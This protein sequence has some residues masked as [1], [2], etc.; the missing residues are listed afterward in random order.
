MI[1]IQKAQRSDLEDILALQ[2]LAYQSEAE[3]YDDP[4]IP[5]L[6]QTIEELGGEFDSG[7]ILKAVDE[8]GTIIG[9]V[10]AHAEDGNVY[11]G[12]LMVHP[13]M[14]R[15]GLGTKL[16]GAIEQEYPNSRYELFTGT[17]SIGNIRLYQRLGYRIF[18]QEQISEDLSF[19]YLEKK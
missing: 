7:T 17:K 9:S 16:L 12:R 19:V 6:K 14:Q 11:I 5:P 8:N 4:D 15:N 13:G 3:L 18:R 1:T 10:R 2:Y